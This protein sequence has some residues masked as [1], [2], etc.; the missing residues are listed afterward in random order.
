[1]FF[2]MLF[3]FTVSMN[4][5]TLYFWGVTDWGNKDAYS[6]NKDFVKGILA[7]TITG[8]GL[9]FFKGDLFFMLLFMSFAILQWS[10]IF[11][12]FQT[13][14]DRYMSL[15]NVFMM[16]FLAHICVNTGTLWVLVLIL[17]HYITQLNVTMRMYKTIDDTF[18][19]TLFHYPHLSK[20]RVY[21]VNT[22]LKGGDINKAWNMAK[23]GLKYEKDFEIYYCC[24]DCSRR[25]G[26]LK[27]AEFFISEAEKYFHV[28]LKDIQAKRVLELRNS[29]I[30]IKRKM[31][32]M[33]RADTPK[34]TAP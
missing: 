26:D 24:A 10:A 16:F 15:A 11:P 23:E 34:P 30:D 6:F 33:K 29:L 32:E 4:Y 7:L 8:A 20:I 21:R 28:G 3:P 31:K 18:D 27:S 9:C 17:G 2:K 14:S 12:M 1:M 19:Y 22:F 13:L 5:P 25:V